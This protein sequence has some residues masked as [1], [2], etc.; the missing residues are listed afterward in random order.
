MKE[1]L[2]LAPDSPDAQAAKDSII[3]WNDKLSAF[4]AA[5]AQETPTAQPGKSLR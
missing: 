1:Y 5:I 2:V 4:R 3:I